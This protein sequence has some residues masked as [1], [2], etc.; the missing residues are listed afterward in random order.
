M[1]YRYRLLTES[2]LDNEIRYLEK[3]NP[4]TAKR[5][6]FNTGIEGKREHLKKQLSSTLCVEVDKIVSNFDNL[7]SS[8]SDKLDN[9]DNHVTTPAVSSSSHEDISGKLSPR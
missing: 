8:I 7:L 3:Y 9:A 2:Q 4:G 6:R 1:S 5:T